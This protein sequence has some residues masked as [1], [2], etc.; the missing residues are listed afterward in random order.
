MSH[1]QMVTVVIPVY[2]AGEYLRP[3][4]ESVINQT[5]RN[6][7]II[8]VD[9][10]STDGCMDTV[11]DLAVNDTRVVLLQQQNGGKAVA[12]NHALDIMRGEFWAIQD[13]DDISYPQ[14]IERQLHVLQKRPEL[15]AVYVGHD[16]FLNE[17]QFAPT[18]G[19]LS[20]EECKKLNEQ[21]EMP[22]HDAT[23][24]YRGSMVKEMRFDPE[25]RIGQGIDYVLRVGERHPICLMGECLY[26]YRINY[27]STI[28]KD[29]QKNI[30]RVNLVIE[31]ACR[32][33]NMNFDQ[34]KIKPKREYKKTHRAKDNHIISHCMES[35]INLK[36]AGMIVES[37]KVGFRIAALH[38]MDAYYYKPLV[39]AILPQVLIRGY[40]ALKVLIK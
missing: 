33:R 19:E 16:L 38:P 18:F 5:Y 3:A 21:F 6:L 11:Q 37:L 22:A 8:I 25:L 15:A 31:K 32:R 2:N 1:N 36:R 10:G 39:Y 30:E 24:M 9:D 4:L 12:L 7:E 17:V 20:V 27:Q 29:P 26:T 14:R 13:A 40:R 23:G 28:R 34:Y 35:E